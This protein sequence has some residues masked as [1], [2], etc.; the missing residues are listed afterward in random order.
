[1]RLKNKVVII[2]GSTTGIGKAIA[3]RC[4]AEGAKVVINGRNKEAG[5]AV[6]KELGEANAVLSIVDISLEIY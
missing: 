1:M 3:V 5:E 6:V 4:V 2:T